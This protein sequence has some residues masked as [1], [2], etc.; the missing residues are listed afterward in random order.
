MFSLA[1]LPKKIKLEPDRQQFR[2]IT[3]SILKDNMLNKSTL[4]SVQSGSLEEVYSLVTNAALYMATGGFLQQ[5][6]Q[7]LSEL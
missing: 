6:N 1:Y 5:G 3:K 4:D 2:Y 7:L